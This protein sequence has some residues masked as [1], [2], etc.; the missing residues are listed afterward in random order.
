MNQIEPR[1]WRKASHSGSEHGNCV[2]AGSDRDKVAIR[3]TAA[4]EAGAITLPAAHFATLL[5]AARQGS[6]TL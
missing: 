2:E 6:L 5:A 1:N 4:R 3:D